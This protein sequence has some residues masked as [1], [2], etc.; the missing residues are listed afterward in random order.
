MTQY[1]YRAVDSEGQD[2]SGTMEGSSTRHVAQILQER[3]LTVNE[4]RETYPKRGLLR[5]VQSLTWDDIE[6]CC[7]HLHSIAKGGMPLGPPLK[8]LAE[9]LRNPRLKPVLERMH[10]DLENGV[11]LE[12][13]VERQRGAF[14]RVFPAILRAGEASGNLAGVLQ[15]LVEYAARM[16]QL[17]NTLQT[18]MIYP[19]LLI[20]ASALVLWFLMVKVVPVYAEIFRDFGTKLPAPTVFWVGVSDGLSAMG[21]EWVL[22]LGGAVAALYGVRRLLERTQTGRVWSDTILL[23]LPGIGRTYYLVSAGRFARTLSLLLTSRVPIL[24]SLE[25]AG[26]VSGSAQ[27]ERAAEEAAVGVAGGERLS[28]ALGRTKLFGAHFRWLLSTG[29]DRGEAETALDSFADAC[30]REVMLRDKMLGLFIAPALIVIMGILI[31]SIVISLYLPIF[32]LGDA[33]GM[34]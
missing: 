29:E 30:Q 6:I 32:S 15:L 11:S 10:Q 21:W 9:D 23:H 13:A 28:D 31:G 7:Q 22:V 4:V 12:E 14:P 24:N 27:I 17:K 1:S 3:G 25:L 8:H 16:V 19:M 5:V 26:S 2:L 18:V 34:G 33:I 20:F